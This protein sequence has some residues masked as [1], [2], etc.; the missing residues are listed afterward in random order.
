MDYKGALDY[1]NER[2]KKDGKMN[3]KI[4]KKQGIKV[5]CEL[6]LS[7]NFYVIHIRN[8]DNHIIG[9]IVSNSL[10]QILE[11]F[12]QLTYSKITDSFLSPEMFEFHEKESQAL[13]LLFPDESRYS[14]CCVC[15]DLTSSKTKCNHT[16]CN[17]CKSK[18]KNPTC[19]MCREDIEESD[20]DS[21]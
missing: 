9:H 17:E 3:L 6:V 5:F 19:P 21:D 20:S 2:L 14:S 15:H 7:N 1:M 18:L 16:L 13:S 4:D 10:E 8:N 11:K 12:K